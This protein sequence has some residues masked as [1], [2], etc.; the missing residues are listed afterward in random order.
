MKQVN[1]KK[2]VVAY[3]EIKSKRKRAIMDFM[4]NLKVCGCDGSNVPIQYVNNYTDSITI[5]D[6]HI[7]KRSSSNAE[8][9]KD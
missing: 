8:K 7:K 4:H 5:M 6:E 1:I 3:N 2:V 9:N